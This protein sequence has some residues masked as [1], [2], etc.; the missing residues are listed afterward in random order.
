MTVLF[1]YLTHAR[2]CVY[3]RNLSVICHLSSVRLKT[4]SI[5][6]DVI[7]HPPY[8]CL[9]TAYLRPIYGSFT[10]PHRYHYVTSETHYKPCA[11]L[12]HLCDNH[13]INPL[14][15]LQRVKRRSLTSGRKNVFL[16]TEEREH[17]E[18]S[19]ERRSRESF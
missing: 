1:I 11:F 15:P 12:S 16:R 13:S 7:R 5:R 14:N 4:S 6:S 9:I 19:I 10:L 17:G 8:N 2:G 18:R 3:F